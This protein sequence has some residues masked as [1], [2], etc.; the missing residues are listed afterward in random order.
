MLIQ[1][2]LASYGKLIKT[3]QKDFNA[4]P[5]IIIVETIFELFSSYN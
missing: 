3:K 2:G 5:L 4:Y 1:K